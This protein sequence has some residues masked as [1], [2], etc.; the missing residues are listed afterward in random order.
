MVPDAANHSEGGG[1]GCL[2]ALGVQ[3]K[4]GSLPATLKRGSPGY[5]VGGGGRIWIDGTGTCFYEEWVDGSLGSA[6]DP[7]ALRSLP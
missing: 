5:S 7:Q 3:V 1:K 4:E 2:D 6:R